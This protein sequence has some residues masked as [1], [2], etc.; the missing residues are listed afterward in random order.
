[1]SEISES[2]LRVRQAFVEQASHCRAL[3]SPFT[4]QVC[5]VIGRRLDMETPVGR[6]I[7]GWRGDPSPLADCVPLRIAGALHALARSQGDGALT[8]LYPPRPMPADGRLWDAIRAAVS[9]HPNVFLDY[10]A[11]TPQTNEVARAAPLMLGLLHLTR[12][13][14][15][16]IVLRE[17]G[18]SA[19]LNWCSSAISM[20]SVASLMAA[21]SCCSS[22]RGKV[23]VPRSMAPF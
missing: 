15:L 8:E 18:A 5:R 3:G 22:L 1:M 2:I 21:P 7:L 16:P 10:L 12:E 11:R 14:Q 20:I 9:A 13:R 17:I 4:A 6:A 23:N 19:G